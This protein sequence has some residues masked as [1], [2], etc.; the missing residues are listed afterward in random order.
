MHFFYSR[1]ERTKEGETTRIDSFNP[2]CVVRSFE[3]PEGLLVLLNDGHEASDYVEA[4]KA[5]GKGFEIKKERRYIQSEILLTGDD[6]HRF[7]GFMGYQT[8]TEDLLEDIKA[9]FAAIN[10]A[11]GAMA[12]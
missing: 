11:T 4:P 7:R 1:T 3:V 9:K 8:D 6:V 10:N 12:E 5:N 2:D